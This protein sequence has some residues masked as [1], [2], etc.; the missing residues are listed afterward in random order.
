MR[1]SAYTKRQ[2]HAHLSSGT[3]YGNEQGERE[4]THLFTLFDGTSQHEP[5]Q[6]GSTAGKRQTDRNEETS[7]THCK[8]TCMVYTDRN[9]ETSQSPFVAV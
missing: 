5:Q 6:Q 9:E 2:L 1:K 4:T 7:P 8:V 3:V